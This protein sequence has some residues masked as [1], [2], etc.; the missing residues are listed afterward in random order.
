MS[1]ASAQ[2]KNLVFFF[3]RGMM[4]TERRDDNGA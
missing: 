1:G 4:E 3:T 2:M